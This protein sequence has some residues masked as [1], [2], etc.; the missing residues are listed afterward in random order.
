MGFLEGLLWL[1][2]NIYHEARSE[3]VIGQLAVAHVTLNRAAQNKQSLEEVVR[4]PYQFS[5][6]QQKDSYL[7]LEAEAFLKSMRSAMYAL[8][9]EDFTRGATYYHHTSVQPYWTGEKV[10]VARYGSHLFYRDR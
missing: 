6:I 1:T 5:W 3:P 9:T 8:C 4:A 7:P 2:L 10:F